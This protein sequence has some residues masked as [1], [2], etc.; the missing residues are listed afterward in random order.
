MTAEPVPVTADPLACPFS[1]VRLLPLDVVISALLVSVCVSLM[2]TIE[3]DGATKPLWNCALRF[4][5]R[6]VEAMDNGA[7]PVE[8]VHAI[9]ELYVHAPE[10]AQAKFAAQKVFVCARTAGGKSS[11]RTV[12]RL[13][14]RATATNTPKTNF[15]TVCRP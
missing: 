15:L 8:T 9:C 7:V 12:V 11:Q 3:L 10:M 6:V 13:A 4:G 14:K 1:A 2:P 5:T